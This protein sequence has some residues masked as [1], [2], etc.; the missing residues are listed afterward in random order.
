LLAYAV[1]FG[2]SM[3]WFGTSAGVALSDMFPEAR[4]VGAWIRH[5][6]HVALAY[7]AGFFVLLALLGWMP[8]HRRADGQPLAATAVSHATPGR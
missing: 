4:S 5:G 6:W 7:V 8:T 3:V 2:G 1:G